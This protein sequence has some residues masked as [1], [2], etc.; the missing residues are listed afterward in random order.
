MPYRFLNIWTVVLGIAGLVVV[1]LMVMFGADLLKASRT[2]PRWKRA[3]VTASLAVLAAVGVNSAAPEVSADPPPV[4]PLRPRPSCYLMVRRPD[5]PLAGATLPARMATLKKLGV[6]EK[7]KSDVLK[8]LAD[9]IRSE[10]PAYEK[11]IGSKTPGGSKLRTKPDKTL[12]QARTWVAAADMRLA[13]GD[14]PLADVPVWRTLTTNWRKAEEAASGRKGR[15][16]FDAKSKKAMLEGLAAAPS[17]LDALAR[18]GYLTNAEAGL[19]K[20]GLDGLDE[21]VERMRPTELR[22][23]TCYK[24]MMIADRDPLIAMLARMPLLEK[25]AKENK[26]HAAAVKRIVEVVD[27]QTTKLSDKKYLKGLTPESRKTAGNVVN[28]AR[29][30]VKKLNAAVAPKPAVTRD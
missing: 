14:K 27:M 11:L 3:L 26:L 18:A 16:P 8:K 12:Y 10:I 7:I 6:M 15:Y 28:A 29:A 13:V 25:I 22:N 5:R 19:L 2:G 30:A 9:Q 20:G 24:P 21:R 1:A 23:A 17:Q 4:V